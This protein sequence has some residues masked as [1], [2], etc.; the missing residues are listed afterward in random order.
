M[1]PS[2]L[3]INAI[4]EI[5]KN[6]NEIRELLGTIPWKVNWSVENI[7]FGA[8]R[9]DFAYIRKLIWHP[10]WNNL[11]EKLGRDGYRT[12]ISI[13]HTEDWWWTL[14]LWHNGSDQKIQTITFN[15]DGDIISSVLST[16]P[17]DERRVVPKKQKRYSWRYT[18][19]SWWYS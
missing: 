16:I 10:V 6:R 2:S 13:D 4:S 12:L 7:L 3:P 8:V 15:Q 18:S 9:I 11:Y 19:T 1:N 17:Q 5:T 14:E